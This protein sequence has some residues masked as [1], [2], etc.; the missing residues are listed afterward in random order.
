MRSRQ[1]KKYVRFTPTIRVGAHRDLPSPRPCELPGALSTGRG[2]E[3]LPLRL[4]GRAQRALPVYAG[5][6]PALSQQAIRA[7]AGPD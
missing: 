7:A 5:T 4:H 6:D 2:D 3:S 1:V